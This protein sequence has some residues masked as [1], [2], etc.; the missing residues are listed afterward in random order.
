LINV[1]KTFIAIDNGIAFDYA[2]SQITKFS[3]T[4]FNKNVAVR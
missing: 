2:Y 4:I 1:F 3:G